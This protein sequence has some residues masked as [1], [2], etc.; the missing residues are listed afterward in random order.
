MAEK[1]GWNGKPISADFAVLPSPIKV[2]N[3][4][5]SSAHRVGKFAAG[6]GNVG[7]SVAHAAWQM[8]AITNQGVPMPLRFFSYKLPENPKPAD[9]IMSV[10]TSKELLEIMDATILGGTATSAF[11]KGRYRRLRRDL[12]GKTGTLTGSHPKGV[13]TWFAGAYP[14]DNPEVVVVSVV[15]LKDLWHIKAANLAAE[16]ILAYHDHKKARKLAKSK[17]NKASKN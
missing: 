4:A 14:I 10:E 13:T 7:L 16:A 15:V 1:F 9:R 8:L 3:P 11:K 6:F 2:P 5:T 17:A 12:G